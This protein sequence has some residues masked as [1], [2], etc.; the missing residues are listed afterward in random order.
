MHSRSLEIV[1]LSFLLSSCASEPANEV[2]LL[3]AGLTKGGTI[4]TQADPSSP[5][6][7]SHELSNATLYAGTNSDVPARIGTAFGM[8]FQFKEVGQAP[9]KKFLVRWH[10]PHAGLSNP[11]TGKTLLTTDAVGQ[12]GDNGICAAG[13]TFTE[14]WELVPGKW[15]AEVLVNERHVFSQ[16]FEIVA[17]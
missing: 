9:P 5:T 17:K 11:V 8:A 12:C 13:W 1:V 6:G 2:K 14:A 15:T 16:S 4:K 10:F 7:L 3:G